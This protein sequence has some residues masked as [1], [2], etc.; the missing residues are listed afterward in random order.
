CIITL[1]QTSEIT[2]PRELNAIAGIT[3]GGRFV[4]NKDFSE[5]EVD[6]M[7]SEFRNYLEEERT[8]KTHEINQSLGKGGLINL[9]VLEHMNVILV[10]DGL[11][12]SMRLDLAEE[13][14][15]P[16]EIESLIVA[17][18]VAS[19]SV[20]DRVHVMADAVYCLSVTDDYYDTDHYYEKKD[21]PNHARIAK[22]IE[23]IVLRW[24]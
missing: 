23:N 13:Y 21:V 14:L 17:L 2:L 9:D 19:V 12:N 1:L 6:E 3:D 11:S 18:P 20:I 10:S 8:T 16:I 4:F 22:T 5:G 24:K 15:K 7:V